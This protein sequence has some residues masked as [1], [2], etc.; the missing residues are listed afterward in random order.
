MSTHT[1]SIHAVS[2]AN[3]YLLDNVEEG[4]FDHKVQPA[5]VEAFLANSS[6]IMVVA[7]LQGRIV[8]MATAIC[9]VH[10]DKPIAMFINE[11]GVSHRVRRQGIGKRLVSALL[12]IARVRGCS[13][14]W[15]ATEVGNEPARALYE[16]LG[17]MPDQEHAVVYLYP[18]RS[19][20]GAGAGG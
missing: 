20:T 18:L 19:T 4:V 3:A 9:Y 1:V 2:A 15:V 10:P 8:G 7:Q 12:E 5:L 6:N 13:S 17:A 14:A 16:S 11:V